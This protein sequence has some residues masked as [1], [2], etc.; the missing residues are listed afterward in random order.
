MVG[1]KRGISAMRLSK[2]IDVTYVTAWRMLHK[3]R[4]VMHEEGEEWKKLKGVI[5]E[6]P[7]SAENWMMRFWVARKKEREDKGRGKK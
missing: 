7:A 6:N 4:M 3:L 5:V 1:D 2:Y